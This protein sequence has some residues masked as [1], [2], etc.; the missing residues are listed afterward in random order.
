[1]V[2]GPG[3]RG[4]LPRSMTLPR[5]AGSVLKRLSSASPGIGI[6]K[7][8]N[9]WNKNSTSP[10]SGASIGFKGAPMKT[11]TRRVAALAIAA[12]PLALVACSSESPTSPSSGT[13]QE[14]ADAR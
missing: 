5:F 10:Y 14:G 9:T 2:T 7:L 13:A 11:L 12:G 8:F 6:Q 4:D 3:E 1:M